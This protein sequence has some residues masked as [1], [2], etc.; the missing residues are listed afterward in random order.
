MP[1][2][3]VRERGVSAEDRLMEECPF[4]GHPTGWFVV[5]WSH[6]IQS[7]EIQPRRYFGSD[8]VVW[9]SV[10]GDA[11]V[12]DAHCAHM[13]CHL[14]HGARGRPHERGLVIGDSVQCPFHGWRWDA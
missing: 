8:L 12:M 11:V 9:R 7:G 4:V 5:A 1:A 3:S 14:A 6:E 13:G 10:S 2:R